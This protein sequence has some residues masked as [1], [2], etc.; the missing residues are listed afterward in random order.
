LGLAP[1]HK[2]SNIPQNSVPVSLGKLKEMKKKKKSQPNDILTFK[3]KI[4]KN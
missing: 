1:S 2:S 3:D 4:A